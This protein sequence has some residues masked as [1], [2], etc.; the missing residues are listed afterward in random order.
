MP[1]AVRGPEYVAGRVEGGVEGAAADGEAGGRAAGES[2]WLL[3]E[4]FGT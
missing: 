3:M 1:S 4:Q 2:G